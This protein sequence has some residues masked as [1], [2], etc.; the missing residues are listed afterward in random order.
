M[1]HIRCVLPPRSGEGHD[2]MNSIYW[3]MKDG[4]CHTKGWKGGGLEEDE[5]A[6]ISDFFT[7]KRIGRTYRESLEVNFSSFF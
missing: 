1:L 6:H 2:D 7:C 3:R 5:P 4:F